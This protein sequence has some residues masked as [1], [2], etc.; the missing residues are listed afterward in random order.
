ME[1]MSEENQN[2]IR[3]LTDFDMLQMIEKGIK[4][5]M[6]HAIHRYTK[7]DNKYMKDYDPNRESSYHNVD[8][9][10]WR[11][12]IM[13]YLTSMKTPYKAMLKTA[14][15]DTSLKLMLIEVDENYTRYTMMNHSNLKEWKFTNVG[16]LCANLCV[17]RKTMSYIQEL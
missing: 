14:T 1:G 8:G 13:I 16:N 17:T 15:N 6:C 9:F 7:A 10:G 3:T 2:K 5:G 4:G 12:D 11:Y